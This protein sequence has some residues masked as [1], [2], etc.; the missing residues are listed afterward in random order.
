MMSALM[1]RPLPSAL[2]LLL[3][4]VPSH[5]FVPTACTS[6]A[7]VAVGR[8][9]V[10]ARPLSQHVSST[11]TEK[12]CSSPATT[13]ASKKEIIASARVTL[14]FSASVAFDAF[15]NLPRQPSWSP[16]L[17]DV[18]YIDDED[19]HND[20][21]TAVETQ[22][23][24]DGIPL[25]ET[26]WTMGYRGFQFSWNAVSTRLERPYLIEWQSTSGL[27]NY[28]SVRFT[29]GATAA[30]NGGDED[31]PQQTEMVLSMK[32]IAPRVIAALFRRSNKIQDVMETMLTGTLLGFRDVV[33]EEDVPTL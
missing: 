9:R 11:T 25:R 22:P 12:E 14:P 27:R 17:K 21:D 1:L 4:L 13:A 3:L 24:V 31:E 32:F 5:A 18:R 33:L 19:D 7:S 20:D 2:L 6:P 26:Q 28:G 30:S 23:S 8:A 29:E 10:P 15:S 16:W